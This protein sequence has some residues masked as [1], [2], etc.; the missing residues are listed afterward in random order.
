MDA[1][2]LIIGCLVF[3]VGSKWEVWNN[4]IKV[5][6]DVE[7]W[8]ELDY[9]CL[10]L[11]WGSRLLSSFLIGTLA[12][13]AASGVGVRAYAIAEMLLDQIAPA[14]GVAEA[15]SIPTGSQY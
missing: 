5:P 1:H 2:Q 11:H 14:S 7:G 6:T 8:D 10:R 12:N 4:I 13:V 3:K 9:L 15:T